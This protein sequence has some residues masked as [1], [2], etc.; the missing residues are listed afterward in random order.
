MWERKDVWRW[1][2]VGVALVVAMG[3]KGWLVFS[4]KLPFNSDRGGGGFDGRPY[5]GWG[6]PDLLLRAGVYGQPGCLAG[7]VGFLDLW[8]P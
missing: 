6:N 7:G 2:G 8:C 5:F 1:L 4:G 3:V